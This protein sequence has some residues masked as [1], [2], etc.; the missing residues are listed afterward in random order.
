MTRLD[1]LESLVVGRA[2]DTDA[3]AIG[4]ND[5]DDDRS[6][7]ILEAG[8][9]LWDYLWNLD[10]PA[11]SDWGRVAGNALVADPWSSYG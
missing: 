7:T 5:G 8:G 6:A 9:W 4:F 1:G 10:D 11:R 3:P 2:R